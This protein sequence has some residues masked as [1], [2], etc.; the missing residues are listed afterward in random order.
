MSIIFEGKLASFLVIHKIFI[1][2]DDMN[3]KFTYRKI[4]DYTVK[5]ELRNSLEINV[6]S[7]SGC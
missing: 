3:A 1:R 7:Q 4:S 6:I 5:N 2:F